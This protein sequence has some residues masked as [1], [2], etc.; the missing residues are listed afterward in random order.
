MPTIES[1][2]K[3][4]WRPPAPA[5]PGAKTVTTPQSVEAAA[6]RMEAASNRIGAAQ[7]NLQKQVG[8][9]NP[10][11]NDRY[12]AGLKTQ[13]D[14]LVSSHQ[15]GTTNTSTLVTKTG[16]GL[17]QSVQRTVKNDN[18]QAAKT[19]KLPTEN[20]PGNKKPSEGRSKPSSSSSKPGGPPPGSSGSGR[21][22]PPS[23]PGGSG[24]GAGGGG[25]GGGIKGPANPENGG[26][27]PY[28]RPGPE[29]DPAI[30]RSR[31]PTGQG[32]TSYEGRTTTLRPNQT[33]TAERDSILGESSQQLASDTRDAVAADKQVGQRTRPTMAGA[34]EHDGVVTS[35]T[36]MRRGDIDVHPALAELY[37]RVPELERSIGHG[38]CSEVALLSDRL[39]AVEAQRPGRPPLTPEEARDYLSGGRMTSHSINH[40]NDPGLAPQGSYTPACRSCA[41][42]IDYLGVTHVPTRV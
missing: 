14:T 25:K 32:A 35:H 27:R 12:S 9:A 6:Q 13:Y 3:P 7:A 22:Q 33:S 10:F 24:G 17:R 16:T 18:D 36:S 42:V 28:D 41:Q 38:R 1:A 34:F 40:D 21:T 20:T 4:P 37:D 11:G 5:A 19:P 29:G 26:F 8:E 30:R 15:R 31:N 39:H 2:S 23:A